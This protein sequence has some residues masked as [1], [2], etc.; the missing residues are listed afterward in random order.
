VGAELTLADCSLFPLFF[1]ATRLHPM[2]GD[3]D[4]TAERAPLARWWQAVRKH[5]A[6]QRVDAELAKAL[7]I[8]MGGGK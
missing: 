1:F 2:L 7:A 3:K 4:P 8:S 5:D 6:I